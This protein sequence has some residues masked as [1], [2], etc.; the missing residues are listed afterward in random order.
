MAARY[1]IQSILTLVIF[2][3]GREVNR[4]IGFALKPQLKRQIDR[5]LEFNAHSPRYRQLATL[6][7]PDYLPGKPTRRGYLESRGGRLRR[8]VAPQPASPLYIWFDM[9]AGLTC[10]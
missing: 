1:G 8:A 5:A 3:G 9:P 2:R 7:C 10:C 4:L 6:S